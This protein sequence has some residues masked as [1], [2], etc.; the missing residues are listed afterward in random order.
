M[1][2]RRD[3]FQ[4]I[5]DPTR[6]NIIEYLSDKE[7]NVNGLS[8]KFAI[9]RQA[10]SLHVKILQECNLITIEQQGRERIC[11]VKYEQLKEIHDW[12]NQFERFWSNKIGNLKHFVE[13]KSTELNKK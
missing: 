11:R 1:A 7:M 6:R 8:E 4:A 5:S 12:T 10:V 3:S 9:S 2:P 13:K